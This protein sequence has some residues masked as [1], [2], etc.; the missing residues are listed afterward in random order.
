MISEFGM[1][2]AKQSRLSDLVGEIEEL[3]NKENSSIEGNDESLEHLR[4]YV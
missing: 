1:N 4:D 3:D 2:Q